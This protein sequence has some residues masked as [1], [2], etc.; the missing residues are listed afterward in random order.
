MLHKALLEHCASI[1][2]ACLT[3]L[4]PCLITER[5]TKMCIKHQVDLPVT[6]LP[7]TSQTQVEKWFG[8]GESQVTQH[9]YTPAMYFG[10]G[11]DEEGAVVLVVLNAK[12][13]KHLSAFTMASTSG[14]HVLKVSGSWGKL[15]RM[16]ESLEG[17]ANKLKETFVSREPAE[18]GSK[19]RRASTTVR[20]VIPPDLQVAS[21]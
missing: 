6:T 8:A 7:T 9:L 15:S 14:I 2:E 17:V 11:E 10:T 1:Y 19:A 20:T 21:A 16:K 4:L 13:I 5:L 12:S 3:P 18:K